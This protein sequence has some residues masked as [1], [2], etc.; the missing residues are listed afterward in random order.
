MARILCL[1]VDRFEILS[2]YKQS[3]RG[4]DIFCRPLQQPRRVNYVLTPF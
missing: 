2:C 4:C 1:G 3:A